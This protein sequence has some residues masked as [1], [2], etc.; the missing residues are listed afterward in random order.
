ML[1]VFEG[2]PV[3]QQGEVVGVA[4]LAENAAALLA[5]LVAEI[6]GSVKDGA[7]AVIV[8][9]FVVH[10]H[11]DHGGLLLPECGKGRAIAMTCVTL[12]PGR[13]AAE[14]RGGGSPRGVRPRSCDDLCGMNEDLGS[15]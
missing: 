15:R 13:F 6:E 5:A 11:L 12:Q 10:E 3:K 2:I 9:D 14:K 7:P 1:G 4:G 8:G